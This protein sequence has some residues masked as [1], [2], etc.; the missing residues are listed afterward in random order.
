MFKKSAIATAL[1]VAAGNANAAVSPFAG[2]LV[3]VVGDLNVNSYINNAPAFTS[4]GDGF[5]VFQRGVSATIPFSLVDDSLSIFPSDSGGIVT[6]NDL[7]AFFGITDTENDDNSGPVDAVW[8]F[9][10]AGYGNLYLELDLAAMGDFEE[11][12]D[13]FE[14][15]YSFDGSSYTNLF[16]LQVDEAASQNYTLEGGGVSTLDDPLT[17]NGSTL[18]NVFTNFSGALA[19]TGSSLFFRVTAETNGGSE[20]VAFRN[21]IIS[22]EPTVVPLPA[23][24]WLLGAGL[25]GLVGL[26]RRRK[27]A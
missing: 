20:A 27:A 23:A 1:L 6:E 12:G 9:D 14:F 18:S 25:L 15:D 5:G 21:V 4:T 2:T 13:T 26:G 19:G 3:P 10:V 17:L 7:D 8:E 24:A 22:G 11:D 16:S